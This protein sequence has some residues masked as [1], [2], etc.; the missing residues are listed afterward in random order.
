MLL[1]IFTWL[2]NVIGTL[3]NW[4][5]ALICIRENSSLLKCF[6]LYYVNKLKKNGEHVKMKIVNMEQVNLT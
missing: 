1:S 6:G 4:E 3:F 5:C 2:G